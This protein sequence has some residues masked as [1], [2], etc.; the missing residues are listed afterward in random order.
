MTIRQATL[1]DIGAMVEL[2]AV[3]HAESPRFQRMPYAPEKV[4][5]LLSSLVES[6]RGFVMVAEHGAVLEGG[7]VGATT[8][9]WACNALIA[10]DIALFVLPG[11]RGG[12]AAARLLKSF[13]AW[14]KEQGAVIATAGISTQVHPD[15]SGALYRALGFKE[16]G[17][18]FDVLGE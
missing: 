9:H 8:E 7:M 4:R 3:M 6:P 13:A 14:C 10:F 1:A 12:I 17:P 15:Q 11:R 2:G 5:A 16:I 18:V